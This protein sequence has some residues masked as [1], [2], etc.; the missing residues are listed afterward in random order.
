MIA[1][2]LGAVFVFCTAV[3]YSCDVATIWLFANPNPRWA[4][5]VRIL[6]FL[7]TLSLIGFYLST[8]GLV[9]AAA[10]WLYASLSPAG[11]RPELK[12]F[13]ITCVAFAGLYAAGVS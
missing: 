5:A 3:L 4:V 10:T 1:L 9:V 13:I 11:D 12:K 2:G 6:G 8:I 7:S